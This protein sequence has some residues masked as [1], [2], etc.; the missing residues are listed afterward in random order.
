MIGKCWPIESGYE[1]VDADFKLELRE[2]GACRP[3]PQVTP[4]SKQPVF[5]EC[6]GNEVFFVDRD[7]LDAKVSQMLAAL[8]PESK[9][10]NLATFLK[11]IEAREVR[12][13]FYKVS[14]KYLLAAMMA[15][16]PR[17]DVHGENREQLGKPESTFQTMLSVLDMRRKYVV[18]LVRDDSFSVF[19]QVRSIAE[20][21]GFDVGCQCLAGDELI[22]FGAGG[23]AIE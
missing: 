22:Q 13:E 14:P 11:A 17:K 4:T 12:S 18:F 1:P 16:E 5:F 3:V 20:E 21:N 8:P 23:R 2:P 7:G 15:L 6:R 10:G 19:R 9:G